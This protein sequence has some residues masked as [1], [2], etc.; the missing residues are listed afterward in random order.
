M[1]VPRDLGGP[2]AH[3]ALLLD[4]VET[5]AA[6]TPPRV[7]RDDRRDDERARGLPAG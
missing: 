6:A 5:L 4:T 7:V 3:P 1:C 2:E